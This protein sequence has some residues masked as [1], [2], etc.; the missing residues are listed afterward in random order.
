MVVADGARWKP[1]FPRRHFQTLG[2]VALCSVRVTRPLRG[3]LLDL[4]EQSATPPNVWPLDW[5]AWVRMQWAFHHCAPTLSVAAVI[6]VHKTLPARSA[7][8]AQPTRFFYG[9]RPQPSVQT[10]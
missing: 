9:L 4:P 2:G 7:N 1:T 5:Y 3:L 6:G 8:A 10:G